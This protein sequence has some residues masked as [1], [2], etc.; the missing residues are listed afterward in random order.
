MRP[1]KG[2]MDNS[3]ANKTTRQL[4]VN[5]N[6]TRNKL[7]RHAL[8]YSLAKLSFECNYIHTQPLD[9]IAILY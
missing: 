5:L 4:K 7:L 6:K 9:L 8:L 3:M 2:T 1:Q